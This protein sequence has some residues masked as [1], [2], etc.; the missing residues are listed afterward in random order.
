MGSATEEQTDDEFGDFQASDLTVVAVGEPSTSTDRS[1]S[2][3]LLLESDDNQDKY[4]ALRSLT[5]FSTGAPQASAVNPLDE[6]IFDSVPAFVP[7][8]T[9]ERALESP[10]AVPQLPEVLSLEKL[11]TP[12]AAPIFSSPGLLRKTV[13][14]NAVVNSRTAVNEDD[15]GDFVAA[16]DNPPTISS[17]P[18]FDQVNLSQLQLQEETR[19][20]ASLEFATSNAPG[21]EG[22]SD[23]CSNWT[24][25]PVDVE[26]PTS[27]QF[28]PVVKPEADFEF[29]D[30]IASKTSDG[31][32]YSVFRD[33][34]N[35]TSD[36]DKST[37][38]EVLRGLERV[39]Q[40]G[41]STFREALELIAEVIRDDCL[42]EFLARSKGLDY[43]LCKFQSSVIV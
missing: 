16:A 38:E 33:F 2:P 43:V 17:V 18:D 19:S 11:P 24:I 41:A 15:F 35:V 7:V 39:L 14:N 9:V 37:A 28:Q 40:V 34:D 31:D 20:V 26:V 4:A 8:E 27:V 32:K 21:S 13:L 6:P 3:P 42:D 12:I 1:S 25:N 23:S 36:D 22:D 5:D 29:T 30:F 10:D